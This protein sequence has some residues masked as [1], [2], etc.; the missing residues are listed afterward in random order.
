MKK[1]FLVVLLLFTSVA[2][3]FAKESLEALLNRLKNL[4]RPIRVGLV[5]SGGGAKGLAHIGVLKILEKSG[6]KI[7]YIGGT[8]MGSII[9]GLYAIG[10]SSSQIRK[11]AMNMNWNQFLTDSLLRKNL[12]IDEKQELD[13]YLLNI[14]F[15][16][17][18]I[19]FPKGLIEGQKLFTRL[20][21]LTFSV[22]N[23]NNFKK[24]KIPFFCI[25]TDL[26][27]GSPVLLEKGSLPKAMRASMSIPSAFTP[28]EINGKLLVDGG[29]VENFPVQRMK[30]R[31]DL[32]IGVDVGTI[33]Y[34]KKEIDSPARVLEQ[35]INLLGD[36]SIKSARKQTDVLI[37]PDIKGFSVSSFES[38]NILIKNGE[39]AALK[40][41]PALLKIAA[42]QKSRGIVVENQQ[43]TNT[44]PTIKI[45][46]I[47]IFGLKKIPRRL[48]LQ[49]SGLKKGMKI[50]LLEIEDAIER[51]Y[52]TGQFEKIRFRL[53]GEGE[54]KTLVLDV[55]E[56]EG[57]LLSLGVHYYSDTKTSLLINTS[58]R[59]ILLD[60]SKLNL[61]TRLGLNPAF[62]IDYT[63]N[64]GLEPDLLFKVSTWYIQR[65]VKQ[66]QDGKVSY[67]LDYANYGASIGLKALLGYYGSL[68]A[69]LIKENSELKENNLF[70]NIPE[71]Q[72]EYLSL[73][74]N[75]ELDTL[76]RANFPKRGIK[77]YSE[78][79]I[80]TNLASTQSDYYKA[81]EDNILFKRFFGHLNLAL[82]PFSFLTFE[83]NSYL[84]HIYGTENPL[85]EQSF[86]LGGDYLSSLELERNLIPFPG[87]RFFEIEAKNTCVSHIILRFEIFSD[88]FI[89]LEGAGAR[90]SD[91]L[92]DIFEDNCD[93]YSGA[94]SLGALTVLGPMRLSLSKR[95]R[96]G[97]YLWSFYIGYHF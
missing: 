27:T 87:A 22:H 72:K 16:N 24:F 31:V 32:V 52:G 63:L 70:T 92:S 59:N 36:K 25:A 82:S 75:F 89:S 43:K 49:R 54:E 33:S 55:K 42:L 48:I 41:F 58:F 56:K 47:K 74:V 73:L 69:A 35:L 10:Y 77:L 11:I 15:K 80:F 65:E 20:S 88:F 6:V 39:I 18:K 95:N 67:N 28:V 60:G 4:K 84:G 85:P 71:K 13:K 57:H 37:L 93:Y 46:K 66:Y 44:N 12:P 21:S 38:T 26:I 79:K 19:I 90:T 3:S 96:G 61:S 50:S 94:L 7:D 86:Y 1:I 40:Q 97:E 2:S 8:S 76:D 51:A 17:F 29:V 53:L 14:R 45:K 64:T 23:E 91:K 34:S 68:Y 62:F 81:D 83:L 5:L 78:M 30:K 9:G